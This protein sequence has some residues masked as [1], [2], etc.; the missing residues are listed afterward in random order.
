[1]KHDE[2]HPGIKTITSFFKYFGWKTWTSIPYVRGHYGKHNALV[3]FC[4]ALQ[5]QL[6]ISALNDKWKSKL[7]LYEGGG[8]VG[9]HPNYVDYC[10]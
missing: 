9:P 3:G 4:N 5:I 8:H 7:G 1:M 6:R 2:K 10:T